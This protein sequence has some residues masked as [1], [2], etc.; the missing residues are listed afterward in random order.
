MKNMTNGLPQPLTHFPTEHLRLAL[1]EAQF[2]L[3]AQKE[4]KNGRGVLVLVSG[5]EMAGKGESLTQL[6]EWMDARYLNVKAGLTAPLQDNEVFWKD[7]AQHIPAKGQLVVLFGNWYG[8]LLAAAMQ[9]KQGQ[10]SETAFD[11]Y[12]MQMH[13][14]EHYLKA[15]N[16]DVLKC[17]FDIGWDCLQQRLDSLDAS[18]Q[19]WQQLHGLDWRNKKQ[20]DQIQQWRKRFTMDWY[21]IDGEDNDQRDL[22]FAHL[23]LDTLKSSPPPE[24]PALPHW[25][26]VETPT[27]LLNP[28]NDKLEKETYKASRK[29]LQK[30][31]AKL[32][33]QH[34]QH[35]SLVIVFEGM[36]AAGKGGSIRR[37]VAP[38]DPRE[39]EIHSIAAPENYELRRPYLWRFWTRMPRIGGVS[40]FDRS[41]Y[42][43]VL[44]E[45]LEGFASDVEWQRAYHEINHFEAQMT[46]QGYVLVKLWLAISKEEQLARFNARKDTPHKR[47]KLTEDDWR[48]REKWDNYLQAATDMLSYTNHPNAPWHV[49]ATND[50]KTA[51]IQILE[52]VKDQLLAA[53]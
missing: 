15:N 49:I 46:S 50:K 11:E 8:D 30:Q 7:Y 24:A 29:K 20:Y 39:Y 16:V 19:K 3:R 31:I 4:D 34:T 44:V 45:R 6:R 33:R 12:V 47:F 28:A 40:I 5:I 32:V 9:Q 23:V 13:Q 2:Q 35:S 14:F 26:V 27:A 37:I 25:P 18:A 48:N 10:L 42:G 38:F 1:I 51:R 36:D 53:Q 52:A 41:W 43:R 22:K 21:E 17:W